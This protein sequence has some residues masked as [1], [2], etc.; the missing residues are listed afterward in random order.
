MLVYQ[1]VL[2]PHY[3]SKLNTPRIPGLSSY[4]HPPKSFKESLVHS[5]LLG[6]EMNIIY[7]LR[8]GCGRAFLRALLGFP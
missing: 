7:T 5:D 2:E 6:C 1:R 8:G 3:G 4:S